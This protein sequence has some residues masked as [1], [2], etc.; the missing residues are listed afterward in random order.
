MKFR[1][2][3]LVGLVF[4]LLTGCSNSSV[5]EEPV[6]VNPNLVV[7]A[8]AEPIPQA[9][10]EEKSIPKT[11]AIPGWNVISIPANY[12]EVYV[13]FYNPEANT[14]LYNLTFEWRLLS[15]DGENFEVIYKSDLIA[16]GEHTEK[17]ILSRSFTEGEYDTVLFVQPYKIS[18]NSPTNNANM[19]TKLVVR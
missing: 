15:E 12:N 14:D 7:D 3:I 18:D 5:I 17:I 1:N 11:V 10:L 16:P 9:P 6:I 13:D 2:I 8:D 19:N 4:C